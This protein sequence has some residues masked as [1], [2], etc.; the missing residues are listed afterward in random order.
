MPNM[1][2]RGLWFKKRQGNRKLFNVSS[3][4]ADV[5]KNRPSSY[6]NYAA[7]KVEW[8]NI[9]N[10]EVI[11]RIGRGK[12]SDVFEGINVVS[13][14][15][16]IIKV[17]KPTKNKKI[18]REIKV[19]QNLFG[20]TNIIKLYDVV[21]DPI[22][23]TPSLI[24]EAVNGADFKSFYL[25][26]TEA[27]I[28][29]YMHEL[30]KALDWAHSNGI[31]HRDLKPYNIVIDPKLGIL[32]LIDWG[33]A[34]FYHKNQEYNPR[35][36]SR[37]FKGPELFVDMQDYD[38]SLDLWS[39]GCVLAGVIFKKEPFFR[40]EDNRDQLIKIIQVLG[41]DEL[42]AWIDKY[43]LTLDPAYQ[44]LITPCPRIPYE[45]FITEENR[46]TAG[47]PDALDLLDKLLR[48]DPAERWTARQAMDHPYFSQLRRTSPFPQ[49]S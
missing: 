12:Y 32:R 33:L 21:R 10:Y 5:N 34:E 7:L 14:K 1:L 22:T 26:L 39:F 28:K 46:S 4:Y 47:N 35:V 29:Y 40:G 11:K 44:N 31:M 43:G 45:N 23:H 8:G 41:T 2:N 16:C 15:K 18:R 24:F 38:Y 42:C 30:L 17:L 48:F 3:V 37:Y 49:Q 9:D 27:E 36:A 25:K 20:G 6:W 19:L 13:N